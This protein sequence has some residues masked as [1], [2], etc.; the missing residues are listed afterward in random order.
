MTIHV[1]LNGFSSCIF[2]YEWLSIS[3][4]TGFRHAH[5]FTT[6]NKFLWIWVYVMNIRVRMIFHIHMGFR[7]AIF[8]TNDYPYS[9]W[10]AFCHAHYCTNET[11]SHRPTKTKTKHVLVLVF[12]ETR[13]L[14]IR[15]KYFRQ[16]VAYVPSKR[17]GER[18]VYP[19][20][21]SSKTA[22]KRNENENES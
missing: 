19:F 20:S 4:W 22:P 1:F 17:R 2:L 15:W 12:V 5:L 3:F 14:T 6:E 18:N 9:F 21:F 10:L 8:C 16:I 7:Y 11:N 13:P